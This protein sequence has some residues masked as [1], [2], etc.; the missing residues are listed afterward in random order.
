MAVEE[1]SIVAKIKG[2]PTDIN[3]VLDEV[4]V[5][6]KEL[7]AVSPK[8][9]IKADAA[10]ALA[11]IETV[12]AAEKSLGGTTTSTLRIDTVNTGGDSSKT[13]AEAAAEVR[14]AAAL[15]VA[16]S[17]ASRASIA[18]MRLDELRDSGANSGARLAAAELAVTETANRAAA[19]STKAALAA[20]ELAAA[21]QQ[22]TA[23]AVEEGA[24]QDA[25]AAATS[26]AGNASSVAG[27]Q[28]LIVAAAI[29]AVITLAGPAVAAATGIA[30][31][32]AGMGAAGVLAIVGIKNEMDNGTATGE[33]YKTVLGSLK[34][35]LDELA[36]TAAVGFLNDFQQ[37]EKTVTENLAPLNSEISNFTGLLGTGMNSVVD[38]VVNGLQVMNPLFV[39][40]AQYVNQLAA[41]F[42]QWTQDGGLQKFVNYAVQELPQ[43]VTTIDDVAKAVVA[44]TTDLAPAGD[45]LLKI[46]SVGS[47]FVTWLSSLPGAAGNSPLQGLDKALGGAAV[48][49]DAVKTATEG[50]TGATNAQTGALGGLVPAYQSVENAQAS[51]IVSAQAA[52]VQMQIEGDAA[53][54][55]SNALTLVNGGTLSLA[56]A[57]TGQA[58]S[59]NS[60]TDS[61]AKNGT[62]IDGN[63]KSAVANQQAILA[64]VQADQQAAEAT[65]KATG[66]TQAGTD[67]LAQSRI[68]LEQQLSAQG[69]LTPAVQAYIETVDQVK[70][71]VGTA[72][73]ADTAAAQS[74][75]QAL[76][77]AYASV[78]RSISTVMTEYHYVETNE[79][80]APA[81]RAND[82]YGGTIASH[83]AG[84]GM[85]GTVWGKGSSKSDSVPAMLSVG[86][87]V[88]Q[89]PYA[90]KFRPQLKMMNAGIDPYAVAASATA[91]QQP[92]GD[93]PI[94]MDGSL[95]GVLREMAN[96][97]AQIVLNGSAKSRATSVSTGRQKVGV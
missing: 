59:M 18:Q 81:A 90:Q 69:L 92:A 12:K 54:L 46:V 93:R 21:Q 9:D 35:D 39:E 89:Q 5:K 72:F 48:S 2:D 32:L 52:T 8:I 34:N 45:A 82:A 40:G 3:R 13:D 49:T 25:V 65:A 94:Y 56:Q 20:E 16:E 73:H 74:N 67:A 71:D 86:E 30:G 29:G 14:L 10:E 28:V 85:A 55:L 58:A 95:F 64:K 43:V 96:S 77:S 79:I 36:Q 51:Q 24:A 60:L 63:S 17:A 37:A 31:G 61:F 11:A 4:E 76:I 88:I 41:G 57:Q 70:V 23:T 50:A 47:G 6:A 38:G 84:G 62:V 66:S 97:E 19:A 44:V 15:T 33:A 42:D 75:I 83:F 7:G 68:A 27:P 91:P 87:E 78:P 80:G 26:S 53:G 22:A 1:G